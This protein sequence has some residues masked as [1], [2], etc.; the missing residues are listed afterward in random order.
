MPAASSASA[1]ES[2]F[3]YLD[4]L[5]ERATVAELQQR[6]TVSDISLADIVSFVRFS[7]RAYLRNL[8]REG[9]HYHAL[10]L[11]WRSGQ[12]SPIHN[13]AGSTCGLRVLTGVA[14]ETIF[15][16]SPC[17]L[18][19]PVGSFDR[20]AGVVA[21]SQ[22][23]DIHQVSNLQPAGTDLVTLHI[24]SPPLLRMDTYSLTDSHIGEF[25]PSVLSHDQG[26][27]I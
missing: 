6:L 2:L 27:G 10:A 25:R 13:H 14:T 19:K 7:D 9:E 5:T 12:R 18:I 15:D 16:R 1:I 21:V 23:A 26:S 24:Y 20:H 11:C 22:D 3:D 17:T 4:N 8:I